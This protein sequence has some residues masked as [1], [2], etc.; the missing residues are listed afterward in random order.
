[1]SCKLLG[2]GFNVIQKRAKILGAMIVMKHKLYK[3]KRR[4]NHKH[5]HKPTEDLFVLMSQ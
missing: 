1:M 2:I 4:H 3:S 5:K